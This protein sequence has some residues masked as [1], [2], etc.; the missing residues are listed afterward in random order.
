MSQDDAW[1]MAQVQQGELALFDLLVSRHRASLIRVAASKLGDRTIAEDIVQETFLAVFAARRS[2]NP[3]F[4]FRTWLWTILLNCCRRHLRKN[5]N[6]PMERLPSCDGDLGTS[7]V[8]E[9]ETGLQKLLALE[10]GE[11]LHALLA[12]LP[13]PQA[14]ALRLRFFGGLKFQEIADAMHSSLGGAKQRVRL[15]LIAL[16]ERLSGEEKSDDEL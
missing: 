13:E 16:A 5:S 15:G 8:A 12:E 6:R 2:F 4:S 7:L 9:T 10:Q 14:D 1:I 3:A 11:Q